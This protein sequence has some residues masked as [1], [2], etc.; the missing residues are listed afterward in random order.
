MVMTIS[1]GIIR[2]ITQGFCLPDDGV[3]KKAR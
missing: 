3:L 2:R 1:A